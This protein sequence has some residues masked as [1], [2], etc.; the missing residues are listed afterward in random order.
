[1]TRLASGGVR[2]LTQV[3]DSTKPCFLTTTGIAFLPRLSGG[4]Q[5]GSVRVRPLCLPPEPP[6]I[7]GWLSLVPHL[8]LYTSIQSFSPFCCWFHGSGFHTL[9]PRCPRSRMWQTRTLWGKGRVRTKAHGQNPAF[10]HTT[11]IIP[12]LQANVWEST[13]GPAHSLGTSQLLC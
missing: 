13:K 3:S 4:G 6:S 1:M 2:I 11:T 8:S 7:P 9:S 12:L 5:T 10:S